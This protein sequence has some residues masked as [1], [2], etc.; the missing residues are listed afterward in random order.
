[1]EAARLVITDS[2]GMQEETSVLGVPCLTMRDNTERPVTVELG[3]S[4]LVGRD[5]ARIRS[6]FQD[7]I[8]GHWPQGRPIPLWDG[9]AGQRAAQEIARWLS[10]GP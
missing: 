9:H 6:A 4:R 8:T 5:P 7:A 2:G 1:M 10:S 3:T